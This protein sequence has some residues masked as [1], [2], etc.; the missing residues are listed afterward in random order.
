MTV[1]SLVIIFKPLTA[2]VAMRATGK[3]PCLAIPCLINTVFTVITI[4]Y[5]LIVLW[6]VHGNFLIVGVN[7]R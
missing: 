1:S 4:G 2:F 5:G 7:A 6:F 3:Y